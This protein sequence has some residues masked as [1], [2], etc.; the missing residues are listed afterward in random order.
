MKNRLQSQG[1]SRIA[2]ICL[3]SAG[4]A[5]L[6]PFLLLFAVMI[7][8]S[9]RGPALFRQRRVGLDGNEFVLYKFRSMRRD[10]SGLKLTAQNDARLTPVGKWLRRYK[11]DELPQLWNVVRGEMSFVGPRPEVSEYVDLEN[12]LWREIL[13]V[14]PGIT[15][16]VAL[17][18]RNEEQLL[19]SVEDKEAFYVEV[20]QPFKL[21]GWAEYARHKTWKTDVRTLFQTV[22]VILP[23]N[24]AP[25]WA[26]DESSAAI[27][28]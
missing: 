13:K 5:L 11:F 21:Q 18:F 15:D 1:L 17:R 20:L 12:P 3:A 23:P 10:S 7:R 9:S 28:D 27:T 16:P 26:S 14:R 24:T 2:E 22:K 19:A 25:P 4:L 6:L 8:S